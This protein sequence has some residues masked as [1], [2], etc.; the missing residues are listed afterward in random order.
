MAFMNSSKVTAPPSSASYI[1]R[2]LLGH[3]Y[4]SCSSSQRVGVCYGISC[5]SSHGSLSAPRCLAVDFVLG[6]H[7]EHCMCMFHS[8]TWMQR[9]TIELHRLICTALLLIS[10]TSCFKH[11]QLHAVHLVIKGL[12]DCSGVIFLEPFASRRNLH[13]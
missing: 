7:P 10:R 3:Q 8:A 1:W 12:P 11:R 4:V 9:W 5:R 6:T 2:I 13:E